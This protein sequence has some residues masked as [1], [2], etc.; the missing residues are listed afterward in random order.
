[1]AKK[2]QLKP[3]KKVKS[4]SKSKTSVKKTP[5]KTTARMAPK[6]KSPAAVKVSKQSPKSAMVGFRPLRDFVLVR[7]LVEAEK[8]AGGLYIPA[9]ALEKPMVGK[10]LSVGSGAV[11]KKGRKR[12]MDVKAGD[13]VLFGKYS[14]TEIQMG[15]ENFLVLRETDILGISSEGV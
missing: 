5:K 6:S 9:T 14:G 12:P 7:R 2:K 3:T 11:D 4:G 8:T 13:Q 15:G 1:M 10:V